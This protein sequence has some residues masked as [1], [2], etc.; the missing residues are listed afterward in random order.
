MSDLALYAIVAMARISV[1][2]ESAT[3]GVL[4]HPEHRRTVN[5]LIGAGL[6]VARRPVPDVSPGHRGRWGILSLT[7]KGAVLLRVETARLAG[8]RLPARHRQLPLFDGAF[9]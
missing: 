7:G 6:V 1:L 4:Y 9:A 2:E 8:K 5:T 3:L